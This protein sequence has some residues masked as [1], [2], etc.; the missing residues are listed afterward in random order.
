ME[1]GRRIP[2]CGS[3]NKGMK[4]QDDIQEKQQ[5][6]EDSASDYLSKARKNQ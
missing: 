3:T 4:V 1:S 5:A 6:R 2:S